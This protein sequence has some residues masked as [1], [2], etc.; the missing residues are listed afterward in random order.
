MNIL[1]LYHSL[2]FKSWWIKLKE[3]AILKKNYSHWEE[4]ATKKDF[5]ILLSDFLFSP[6]GFDY[7]AFFK[8][9]GSLECGQ[10]VPTIKVCCIYKGTNSFTNNSTYLGLQVQ[11][12]I[13]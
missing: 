9:D 5:D 8:F 2:G 13:S 11:D 6:Y 12:G 3:Y 1:L 7:R 10:P 4:F